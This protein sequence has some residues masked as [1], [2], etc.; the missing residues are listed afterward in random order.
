VNDSAWQQ[1]RRTE[2]S[3]RNDH[4]ATGPVE[5]LLA[6]PTKRFE[7][8]VCNRLPLTFDRYYEY[9]F[10]CIALTVFGNQFAPADAHAQA[11]EHWDAVIGGVKCAFTMQQS[12][13][14][15]RARSGIVLIRFPHKSYH[16]GCKPKREMAEIVVDTV[17]AAGVPVKVDQLAHWTLTR[18][19]AAYAY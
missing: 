5:D 4:R 1:R 8:I 13:N 9:L 15:K 11:T 2:E 3:V 10:S 18:R 6:C 16:K 7:E 12:V 14:R 19:I 17:I